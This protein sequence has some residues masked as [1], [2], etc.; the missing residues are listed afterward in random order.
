MVTNS[1]IITGG[2]HLTK[3][4]QLLSIEAL[5]VVSITFFFIFFIEYLIWRYMWFN[6]YGCKTVFMIKF[7]SGDPD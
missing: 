4:E 6:R 5:I 1:T 2:E 7:N 3:E